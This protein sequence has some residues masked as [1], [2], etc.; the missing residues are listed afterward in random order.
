M[1]TVPQEGEGYP[2][3]ATLLTLLRG[4]D[5]PTICN[6]VEVAQGRRGFNAFTRGTKLCSAPD[7][8]PIVG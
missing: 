7:E 2:M 6:A 4:V 1:M 3:D 8:P 5:T